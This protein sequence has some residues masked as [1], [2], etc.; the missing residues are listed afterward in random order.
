MVKLREKEKKEKGVIRMKKLVMLL[1]VLIATPVFALSIGMNDVGDSNVAIQYSDANELNLPRAFALKFTIDAPA[2]ITAV[3]GYKIDG[4][5][6]SGSPGYG[7][8]PARIVIDGNG[9]PTSYGNPLA[10]PEDPGSGDGSSVVVLEFGSLYVG[11]ANAPLTGD[12]LCTLT[13]ECN[14]ATDVN[15]TM[16]DEDVIRGGVLLEDGTPVPVN[17]TIGICPECYAGQPDYAEWEDAGKPD[18]WCYPKQCHGDADGLL[19]GSS[20]TGF[21]S[22]GALDLNV[23]QDAWQIK[24]P[25]FGPGITG[26]QG[27]AD[28]DHTLGG[29]SKTGYYRVGALD[30]NILQASWQVKEPTFG[31]GI[32]AD[33]L[34]GNLTP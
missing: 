10:D 6:T 23:L 33:C 12:T 31:P 1:A 30:L 19:G 15:L 7:I 21:Y 34:P 5:S 22:V 27:C 16:V 20:K 24:N 13:I 3:S 32:P 18:C 28:F 17:E 4:E 26:I 2:V 8:Y 29:S 14:G 11:E 25:P 9:D